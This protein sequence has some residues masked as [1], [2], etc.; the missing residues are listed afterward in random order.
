MAEQ[1]FNIFNS[2]Y[3]RSIFQAAIDAGYSFQTLRDFT[4]VGCPSERVFVLRV[5][6]DLHP[7]RLRLFV[8]VAKEFGITFTVFIRVTGPYNFLWYPCFKQIN[9]AAL[10]GCEIGLHTSAV[11]W[12][13]LNNINTHEASF[14]SELEVLR[15]HFD[16]LGVAPHR[17][18]NYTYN[19]LPWINENW[20]SIQS[21][22][23]LEYHAYESRIHNNSIY[24]NEGLSPHLGWRNMTPF[25]AIRT[26]K[27]V[28]LLLHPHWWF[29]NHPFE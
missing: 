29:V 4:R 25:D 5:D 19:T 1:P 16:V 12:G 9:D 8:E 18:I 28:N 11:E 7:E 26:G 17:D 6:L 2:V 13:I 3:L 22:Y 10:I 27:S 15:S 20:E 24:V 21:N 23:G 14:S